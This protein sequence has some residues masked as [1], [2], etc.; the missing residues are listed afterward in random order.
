M[1]DMLRDR[2]LIFFANHW[3]AN[4]ADWLFCDKLGKPMVRNKVALNSRKKLRSTAF[5]RTVDF[6]YRLHHDPRTEI[7]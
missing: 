6:P 3:R 1:S 7:A 5:A 4:E 2:L